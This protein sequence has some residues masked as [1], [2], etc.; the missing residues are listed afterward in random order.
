M[1]PVSLFLGNS[2]HQKAK[3]LD[4]EGITGRQVFLKKISPA[5]KIPSRWGGDRRGRRRAKM[6][7]TPVVL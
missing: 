5:A 1:L 7:F 3:M 6:V 2:K 4:R